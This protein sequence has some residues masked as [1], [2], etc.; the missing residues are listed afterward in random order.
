MRQRYFMCFLLSVALLIYGVEYLPL[1]GWGIDQLFASIWITFAVLVI[2]GNGL[3]LLY[4]K[5]EEV[6]RT[7]SIGK[8]EQVRTKLRS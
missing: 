2:C 1:T 8:K 3:Q 7:V 5:N 6:R 4:R